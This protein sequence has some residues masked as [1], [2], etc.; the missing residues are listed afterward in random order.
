VR[1]DP[2]ADDGE[3]AI[4]VLMEERVDRDAGNNGAPITLKVGGA[5]GGLPVTGR[6]TAT[7]AG[8]GLLLL[9]VGAAVTV[10]LRRRTRTA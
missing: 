8:A 1:V 6:T 2:G 10:V 4:E 7:V 5:G 9:L 3:G